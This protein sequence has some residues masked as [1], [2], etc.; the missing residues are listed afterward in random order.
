[1]QSLTHGSRHVVISADGT[2]SFTRLSK[3]AIIMPTLCRFLNASRALD[4]LESMRL[5]LS[6]PTSLNDPFDCCPEFSGS[7]KYPEEFRNNLS[8][9]FLEKRSEELGLLCFSRTWKHH[10]LW[11][12]YADHHRGIALAFDLGSRKDLLKV[13]Y[14]KT[15]AALDCDLIASGADNAKVGPGFQESFKIKSQAWRYEEETRLLIETKKCEQQDGYYFWPFP[16]DALVGVILGIRCEVAAAYVHLLLERQQLNHAK[17]WRV[18][19]RAGIFALT[20]E[21]LIQPAPKAIGQ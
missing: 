2:D 14:R 7:E 5:S 8:Q 3:A 15:R 9:F 1:M 6:R 17:V 19:K 16:K 4:A 18:N 20:R 10:L 21:E 12:H 13:K 11:S